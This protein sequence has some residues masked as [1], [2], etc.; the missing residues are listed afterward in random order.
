MVKQG[1]KIKR[2]EI[3]PVRWCQHVH[4]HIWP[5]AHCSIYW[6]TKKPSMEHNFMSSSGRD[7]NVTTRSTSARDLQQNVKLGGMGNECGRPCV[8]CPSPHH[9]TPAPAHTHSLR[10]LLLKDYLG[11]K[12]WGGSR[13]ICRGECDISDLET[14]LSGQEGLDLPGAG[15]SW[16][17]G[18]GAFKS[19][20][21]GHGV[22]LSVTVLTR[23]EWNI[24]GSRM[25]PIF[26][27]QQHTMQG[28]RCPDPRLSLP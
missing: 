2:N 17:W 28:Q 6:F 19:P 5:L 1:K 20:C 27:I 23:N 14:L 13:E 11:L 4:S 16:W 21:T 24:E 12:G 22:L 3:P 7:A 8:R 15:M 18:T 10:A 26:H 9:S 25:S